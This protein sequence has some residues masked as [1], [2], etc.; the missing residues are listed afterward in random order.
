[1]DLKKGVG[2]I[3]VR[4]AQYIPLLTYYIVAGENSRPTE[5]WRIFVSCKML[6]MESPEGKLFTILIYIFYQDNSTHIS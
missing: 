2:E 3:F 1:M 4:N 6:K 5:P